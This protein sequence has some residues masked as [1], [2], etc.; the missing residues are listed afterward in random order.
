MHPAQA[1]SVAWVTVPDPL[2]SIG[3]LGAL[4]LYLRYAEGFS[5]R[6]QAGG[7]KSGKAPRTKRTRS[8]VGWLIA[9]AAAGLAA[10]LAKETAIVLPVVIFVLALC[11]P[12]GEFALRSAAKDSDVR[13]HTRLIDALRQAV[14]FAG[15]SLVYFL[16]RFHALGGKLGSLTQHLP[17]CCRGRR[18]SGST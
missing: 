7:K 9:S 5:G 3:I 15:V 16:L 14:P 18:L 13:L 4:L 2:M 11:V 8:Q 6:A 1:E 17:W 10:L 12:R